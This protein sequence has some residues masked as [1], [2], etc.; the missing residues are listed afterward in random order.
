MGC[1]GSKASA[2]EPTP[3]GNSNATGL[4]LEKVEQEGSAGQPTELKRALNR[5]VSSMSADNEKKARDMFKGYRRGSV[6]LAKPDLKDAHDK[7]LDQAE[8]PRT[9]SESDI[10]KMLG[11][12]DDELFK[13]VFRLFDPN[14]TGKVDADSFVAATALLTTKAKEN[15]EEQLE[16]CFYMFDTTGDGVLTKPEFRAMVEA[17]VA[18]NLFRMLQTD[19]GE[20]ALE[21]QLEK[22]FSEEMLR[23][24]QA[25]RAYSSLPDEERL[26]EAKKIKRR[27]IDEG[28]DEQ[29]NLPS[30]MTRKLTTELKEMVK[31]D[32]V[33]PKDMFAKAEKEVF[34]LM[35]RNAHTRFK[36]DPDAVKK[37]CDDFFA[38]ADQEGDGQVTYEEYKKWVADHPSVLT[39]FRQ[40]ATSIS[41]MINK[42]ER[43][44][45]VTT[46]S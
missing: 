2:A 42:V 6:A 18:L 30:A 31:N 35:D 16:A 36:S 13:F 38:K 44:M 12:V 25:V 11:D 26:A 15:E 40:L 5:T 19:E 27:F 14:G 29:V 3:V 7:Q 37:I 21:A 34:N 32:T 46:P 4:P 23:F 22:E 9:M 1:G 10:R 28:A 24:W 39:F 45:S 20:K 33:P 41:A 8:G 43:R 17:T